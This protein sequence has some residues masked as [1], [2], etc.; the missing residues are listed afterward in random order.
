MGRDVAVQ[1]AKIAAREGQKGLSMRAGSGVS[2]AVMAGLLIACV[3][4]SACGRKGPLEAPP[5]AVDT[6]ATAAGQATTGYPAATQGTDGNVATTPPGTAP[7]EPQRRF[8]LDF[9]L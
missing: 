1:I 3:G 8:F 9:L 7:V 4:L 5:G 2:A 6:P